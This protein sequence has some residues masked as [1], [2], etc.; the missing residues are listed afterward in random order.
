MMKNLIITLLLIAGVNLTIPKAQS[1]I[2]VALANSSLDD[3][4]IQDRT[5]E[6]RIMGAFV[7]TAI[8]AVIFQNA[9]WIAYVG[10]GLV[11]L[12]EEARSAMHKELAH[13]F[14][15]IEDQAIIEDLSALVV[16]EMKYTKVEGDHIEV[17]LSEEVVLD[18]IE[19]ADL[20]EIETLKVLNLLTK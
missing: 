10:A 11:V 6:K 16:N 14:P 3:T 12:D 13:D 5:W 4:C 18:T 9:D 15:F 19:L 17:V 20:T 8:S 2:I 7:V 1:G